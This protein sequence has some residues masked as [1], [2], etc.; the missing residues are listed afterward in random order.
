MKKMIILISSI[1]SVIAIGLIVT[2]ILVTQRANAY[3]TIKVFSLEGNV[4][5]TRNSEKIDAKKDMKLKNEDVLTTEKSSSTILKLDSDK[6]V[7]VKENT[8]IR[9]KATGK[10][11][12]TKTR[13]IVDEGGVVV[14][15]KE[16]LR[17]KESFEIAT[18]NSIMAVRGT[19]F[20]VFVK[21]IIDEVNITYKL[22]RGGI[23][24][25]VIDTDPNGFNIGSFNMKPMEQID[26]TAKN[27][28]IISDE[29]LI[30]ALN[31]IDNNNVTTVDYTD[32]ND[33]ISSTD[34]V[35]LVPKNLDYA[36]IVDELNSIPD[37]HD[38]DI[39]RIVAINSTFQTEGDE[40][41]KEIIYEQKGTYKITATAVNK[42]GHYVSGWSVNGTT[43]EGG[44]TIE[45]TISTSTVIY[46]IYQEGEDTVQ[47]NFAEDYSKYLKIDNTSIDPNSVLLFK[48]AEATFLFDSPGILFGVIDDKGNV[49]GFGNEFK[50]TFT[51]SVTLT[52]YFATID[53]ETKTL[54]ATNSQGEFNSKNEL[55]INSTLD[56][57]KL[58]FNDLEFKVED[59]I[60]PSSLINYSYNTVNKTI[61]FSL[62]CDES[63]SS[64]TINV[65]TIT[66]EVQVETEDAAYFKIKVMVDGTEYKDITSTGLLEYVGRMTIEIT[67]INLDN[68]YEGAHF[69][70]WFLR[71]YDYEDWWYQLTPDTKLDY[72]YVYD[73]P[74]RE[75]QL[76]Y[77]VFDN[78]F[79]DSSY[80]QGSYEIIHNAD[81]TNTLEYK[82]DDNAKLN[83]TTIGT[84]FKLT[85]DILSDYCNRVV[86]AGFHPD[87]PF[88]LIQYSE[89]EI[90]LYAKGPTDDEYSLVDDLIIDTTDGRSYEARFIYNIGERSIDWSRLDFEFVTEKKNK[91]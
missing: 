69:V 50:Y 52:L 31:D 1:A 9:L 89:L 19:L 41:R 54:S 49:I 91:P 51:Q 6:Y 59:N 67:D 39:N 86:F 4:I 85:A 73:T 56:S 70:G 14:E 2:I 83:I 64:N 76:V 81:G 32:V 74:D 57:T 47:I 88:Y 24:L 46:P 23:N 61:N 3:R 38:K 90:S 58:K 27:E 22:I 60:I 21:K 55:F 68:M 72:H 13:I 34:K 17:E 18:S 33:Y 30:N 62:K 78:D 26:I 28:G 10:K 77:P 82:L 8:T 45:L 48:D 87:A 66:R 11:N 20:S 36:D 53:A 37:N 40:T 42:L 29:T 12:N 15:V 79:Y 7:N 35:E 5:V 44:S 65:N 16:K 43:V 84:S 75:Y 63:I 25:N 80:Y 71:N